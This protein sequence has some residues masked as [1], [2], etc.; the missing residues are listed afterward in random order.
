MVTGRLG[1]R[2]EVASGVSATGYY[3][4]VYAG[5][6]DGS[7]IGVRIGQHGFGG[8]DEGFQGVVDFQGCRPPQP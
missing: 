1:P 6:T 7:Y 2:V 5:E 4:V 8:T 3:F